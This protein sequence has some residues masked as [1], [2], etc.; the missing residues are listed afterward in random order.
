MIFQSS[1]YNTILVIYLYICL[2]CWTVNSFH[3]PGVKFRIW[4]IIDAQEIF[5]LTN[6]RDPL[7][8]CVLVTSWVLPPAETQGTLL[9]LCKC[10]NYFYY[11]SKKYQGLNSAHIRSAINVGQ[12]VFS[13]PLTIS[14]FHPW[15]HIYKI[16]WSG[17]MF[18]K[19]LCGSGTLGL[20]ELP[21]TTSFQLS[22]SRP[23]MLL[24]L[25]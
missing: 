13:C 8:L 20:Q 19:I 5:A 22:N 9:G 16:R 12:S 23:C 6:S 3:I 4:H 1:T 14:C 10:R 24:K 7:P 18:P 17:K 2:P 21:R 11:N 25:S 15:V